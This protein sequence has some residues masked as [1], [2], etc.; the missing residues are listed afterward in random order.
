MTEK[1]IYGISNALYEAFGEEYGIEMDNVE[2]NLNPPCFRILTL[3]IEKVRKLGDR[4]QLNQS[5][6]I[7]YFPKD[8][9]GTLEC[10]AVL[11]RMYDALEHI[12]VDGN[13]IWGSGMHGEIQNGVLHFFVDYNLFLIKPREKENMEHADVSVMERMDYHGSK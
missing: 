4:Y 5:F 12:T 9:K 3:N 13:L 2:Q 1:T 7:H 11:N 10:A 6:D 8:E